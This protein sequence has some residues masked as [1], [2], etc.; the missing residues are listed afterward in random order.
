M[1]FAILIIFMICVI[2]LAI[3]KTHHKINSEERK[4]KNKNSQNLM[5]F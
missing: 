5:I 1:D 4:N 3:W 2:S